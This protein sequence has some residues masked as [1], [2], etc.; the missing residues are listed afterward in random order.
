MYQNVQLPQT[1]FRPKWFRMKLF[2]RGFQR[3]MDFEHSI[4]II[5]VADIHRFGGYFLGSL[6]H[7]VVLLIPV[8]ARH[9]LRSR[10]PWCTA[11]AT[12]PKWLRMK[13]LHNWFQWCINLWNSVSIRVIAEVCD[14]WF[15]LC[16]T[17]TSSYVQLGRTL[18]LWAGGGKGWSQNSFSFHLD[19]CQPHALLRDVSEAWCQNL[20][21]GKRD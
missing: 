4:I 11:Q 13:P 5:A 16:T 21:G 17:F 14:A 20:N 18:L 6:Q 10:S 9:R 8:V 7:V 15:C 12:H 1:T 3:C 2:H 19:D